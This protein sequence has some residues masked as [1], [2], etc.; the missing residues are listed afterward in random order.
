MFLKIRVS[1]GVFCSTTVYQYHA[2]NIMRNNLRSYTVHF[3]NIKFF[4]CPTNAH[5][6]FKTFKLLKSFNII[7]VAPTCFGLHK[8]SGSTQ[9]VLRQSY[10]VDIGYIY[11]YLKLSILRLNILFS[12]A[13]SVDRALCRVEL[14][15]CVVHDPHA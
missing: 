4:I 13:M 6:S 5:N 12:L 10:N 14:S 2:L 15:L 1:C 7:I 9:L 8:P 11:R 3:D